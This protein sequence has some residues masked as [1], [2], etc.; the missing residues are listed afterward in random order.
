MCLSLSLSGL[1]T[2][3]KN[4]LEFEEV[5]EGE[6]ASMTC[7]IYVLYICFIYVLYMFYTYVLYM[8]YTFSDVILMIVQSQ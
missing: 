7:F 8:F 2:V 4:A 5:C 6:E 1:W 3:E